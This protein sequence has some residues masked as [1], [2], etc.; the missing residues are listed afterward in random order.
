M[1]F[2]MLG[3]LTTTPLVHVIGH[4]PALL[5]WRGVIALVATV[6]LLSTSAIHDRVVEGHIHPASLWIPALLFAWASV[7][8]AVIVPSAAWREL[9][10]WV[11]K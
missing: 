3:A 2:A 9:A 7:V 11:V 4:W 8:N 1:L 5:D 10:A 6:V